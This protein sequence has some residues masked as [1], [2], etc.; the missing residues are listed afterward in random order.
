MRLI[1][2][3][4]QTFK[5]RIGFLCASLLLGGC[6][7]Q[8]SQQTSAVNG[9][10]ATNASANNSSAWVVAAQKHNN[11][12]IEMRY[13]TTGAIQKQQQLSV[14]IEFSGVS[15]DD[16]AVQ[17]RLEGPLELMSNPVLTNNAEGY[18][19]RL[20][21]NQP[22]TVTLTLLAKEDGMHYIRMQMSQAGRLSATSIA[23]PVGKTAAA[24]PTLGKPTTTPDGEKLI[25]MPA[26]QK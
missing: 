7:M 21:K 19:L 8:T 6:G 10:A 15:A 14:E 1:M 3:N 26:T 23:I 22:N 5:Q 24:M 20:T 18:Q 9:S 16:A 2:F 4:S 12:G 25:V 13:K 17:M 11:S